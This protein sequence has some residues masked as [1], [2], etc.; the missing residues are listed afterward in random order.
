MSSGWTPVGGP[1]AE[2]FYDNNTHDPINWKRKK[3]SKHE[4]GVEVE[5][6]TPNAE[7]IR[8]LGNRHRDCKY[9]QIGVDV[10]HMQMIKA[11]ADNFLACKKPIDAMWRCYTEEKYGQS[12]RDAPQYTKHYEAKFYDCL[13]RDASGLDICMKHFGNMVRAIHRSGES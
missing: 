11:G 12:L 3:G 7:E 4:F 9:Y 6:I 13:F 8:L 5:R 10:C 1:K 2:T